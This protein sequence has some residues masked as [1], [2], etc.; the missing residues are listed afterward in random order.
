MYYSEYNSYSSAQNVFNIFYQR[1]N[2]IIS[3][4]IKSVEFI[5]FLYYT[6]N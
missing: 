1:P 2:I 4:H 6:P 3:V 5:L